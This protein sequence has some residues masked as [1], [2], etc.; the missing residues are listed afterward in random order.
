MKYMYLV[1][2]FWFEVYQSP[3][4]LDAAACSSIVQQ[5]C[6]AGFMST[7]LHTATFTTRPHH[8]DETQLPIRSYFGASVVDTIQR[9]VAGST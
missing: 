5:T 8:P 6:F 7:P 3:V 9:S 1:Q 2:D 4:E